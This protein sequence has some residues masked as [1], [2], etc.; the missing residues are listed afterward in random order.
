MRNV[1]F[2]QEVN[3]LQDLF[4]Q[5]PGVLLVQVLHGLQALVELVALEELLDEDD[6]L[7]GRV[8]LIQ[9]DNVRVVHLLQYVDLRN[10]MLHVVSYLPLVDHLDGT[11]LTCLLVDRLVNLAVCS[12]AKFLTN[13]I[14]FGNFL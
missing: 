12:L 4:H 8:I 7:A 1:M 6:I 2:V 9:L 10:D 11:R 3:G 5:L 13:I 14:Q